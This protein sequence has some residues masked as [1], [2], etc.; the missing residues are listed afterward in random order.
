MCADT[1]ECQHTHRTTFC[2][3]VAAVCGYSRGSVTY[4][5]SQ[6]LTLA[7]SHLTLIRP[8]VLHELFNPCPF[9]PG[10][11]INR[12]MVVIRQPYE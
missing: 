9:T 3:Y 5:D 1:R 4:L 7:D 6:L 10:Q 12:E 8:L 11:T 2:V